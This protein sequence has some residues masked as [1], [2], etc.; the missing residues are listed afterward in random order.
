VVEIASAIAEIGAPGW[1]PVLRLWARS[2][3]VSAAGALGT[4][5]QGALDVV[6]GVS[7]SI[8]GVGLGVETV[9]AGGDSE[10]EVSARLGIGV[11]PGGVAVSLAMLA[12]P[13]D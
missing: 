6:D 8:F 3:G 4:D 5:G 12:A 11:F 9:G 13:I 2:L 10:L 1:L 7:D